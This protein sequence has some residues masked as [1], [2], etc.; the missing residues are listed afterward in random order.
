MTCTKREKDWQAYFSGE[1]GER[2]AD[3]LEKHLRL[4]PLC[5]ERY[6]KWILSHLAELQEE[7]GQAP[8]LSQA[9]MQA[10]QQEKKQGIGRKFR[11]SPL[12]IGFHYVLAAGLAL[13]L[14]GSGVFNQTLSYFQASGELLQQTEDWFDQPRLKADRWLDQMLKKDLF[15]LIHDKGVNPGD[16]N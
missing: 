2:E 9:I 4:C 10:I 14:L 12:K 15:H 8:D 16:E 1:L 11:P 3:E 6:E 5:L 13:F 7:H